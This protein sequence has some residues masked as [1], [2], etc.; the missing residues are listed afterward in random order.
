MGA[1]GAG[2]F[3]DDTAC[4]VR[5]AFLHL[6]GA[7]RSADEA[8]A[9]LECRWRAPRSDPDEEPV[10]W[11]ALA[12][13]QVRT[14]RLVPRVR[15]RTLALI[16]SGGD[17]GAFLEPAPRRRRD[18]VLE[19][20]KADLL[21]PQ[22]P[23]T[24]VRKPPRPHANEWSAGAVLAYRLP[25]GRLSLWRVVDHHVDAGGRYAVVE[26]LRGTHGR[27]PSELAAAL[28]PSA[29]EREGRMRLRLVLLPW[30]ETAAGLSLAHRGGSVVARLLAASRR[31]PPVTSFRRIVPAR[32][33]I[34]GTLAG[35][36]GMG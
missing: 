19:K 35:R 13:V 28:M 23:P 5:D 6:V 27:V 10:F 9:E 3:Q 32:T 21:G 36:L 29:R 2:I 25:S 1:W 12:A 18:A 14:G 8:T 20:L 22:R 11:F 26:V 7:G 15:D 33:G 31:R 30:Q 4:E 34:D 24:R 16:A 17:S